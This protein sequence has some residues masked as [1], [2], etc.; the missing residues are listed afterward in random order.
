M[1]HVS[2]HEKIPSLP[3]V[4][5]EEPVD[6]NEQSYE[7]LTEFE[8]PSLKISDEV[9]DEF[10]GYSFF[11]DSSIETYVSPEISRQETVAYD[12]LMPV[13]PEDYPDMLFQMEADFPK[14]IHVRSLF[15]FR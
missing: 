4:S 11:S 9:S 15:Y 7:D 10:S 3:E 13:P 5:R 2:R 6:L 12:P 1:S 14:S 8:D